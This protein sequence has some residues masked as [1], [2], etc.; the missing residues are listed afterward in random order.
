MACHDAA[1]QAQGPESGQRIRYIDRQG[2]ED[3]KWIRAKVGY[4]FRVIKRLLGF[5][6]LRCRSLKENTAQL[7]TLFALSNM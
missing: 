5:V 2:Q 3:Q 4:P 6:K 7:V 1:G